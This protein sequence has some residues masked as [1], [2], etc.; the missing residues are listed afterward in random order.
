[1]SDGR[2]LSYNERQRLRYQERMA[3]LKR[4][5]FKTSQMISEERRARAEA[6]KERAEREL[7]A[8]L[9]RGLC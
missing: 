1:M 3:S 9:R 4:I 7:R 2:Q 8:V 6:A 5:A